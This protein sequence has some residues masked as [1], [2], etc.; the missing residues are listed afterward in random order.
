VLIAECTLNEEV[1]DNEEEEGA[2]EKKKRLSRGTKP[3]EIMVDGSSYRSL[4]LVY[5]L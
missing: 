1:D 3:R 5:F 4:I 2:K